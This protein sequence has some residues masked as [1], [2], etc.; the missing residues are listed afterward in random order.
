[1]SGMDPELAHLERTRAEKLAG[2]VLPAA[3]VEWAAAEVMRLA[4]VHA[5]LPLGGATALAAALAWG[6]AGRRDDVPDSLPWWVAITGGWLTAAS[7]LGP[8]DWWPAPVLTAAWIVIALAARRAA[9]RHEAVVSAREWRAT[10]ADWLGKRHRWGLGGTHLLDYRETWSDGDGTLLAEWYLVSTKGTGKLAS[11]FVGR[12][13]A[14]RIAE[15]EDLPPARVQVSRNRLAG[16][17]EILVTR[18]A[19]P[20]AEPV[21]H[22]FAAGGDQAALPAAWSVADGPARVGAGLEIPLWGTTGA[23]TVNVVSI[24]GWGKTVVLNGLSER[25]TAATDAVQVRINLSDKGYAEP[26]R[27]GPSCLL[28]AFGPEQ[29]ARAVAVLRAV[30]KIIEWRSRRYTTTFYAPS[31]Q[32]PLI[33]VIIDESDSSMKFQAVRELVDNIATK[34][35]EPGVALVKAG[36]RGT[37]DYS[38]KKQKSQDEVTVTGAV[39]S[40][41]EVRHAAG[42]AAW[43]IPDMA[44]LS[45]GHPGVW[46]VSE[47]G[48]AQQRDRAWLLER[49]DSARIAAD[50]AFTQPELHPEC[51]EFLGEEFEAL[52]STEVFTRWAH[53]RSAGGDPQGSGSGAGSAPEPEPGVDAKA[54]ARAAK[55]AAVAEEDPLRGLD[56]EAK[57]NDKEREVLAALDAKNAGTRRMLAETAATP[58]PQMPPEDRAA[59]AAEAW[60]HVVEEAEIPG[61]A[62]SRLLEM[63]AAPPSPADPRGGTTIPAVAGEFGVSVWT[64]RKWLASLRLTS[65]VYLDGER[66]AARWRLAPPPGGG[67]AQ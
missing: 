26:E 19:D 2:A 51:R 40:Q 4:D 62:R 66:K 29:Q 55:R 25:I 15:A 5:T 31:R 8:L 52:L 58:R 28:T 46:A 20:W 12:G 41:G 14:E 35:R 67:D 33:V 13:A 38:S 59:A 17:L 48:G 3:V 21:Q 7:D 6:A 56:W 47:L 50:R 45:E 37:V 32:D 64:A 1:M 18:A 39:R 23:K 65:A 10:R 53:A 30:N 63:L 36:Q 57:L 34:G 54:P 27:W 42:S 16:R 44:A 9:H 24:R 49:A 43:S 60:R 11:Q 22:P 61:E